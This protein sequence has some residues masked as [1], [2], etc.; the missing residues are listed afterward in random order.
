MKPKKAQ[1]DNLLNLKHKVENHPQSSL[2]KS[3]KVR[4]SL[5]KSPKIDLKSEYIDTTTVVTHCQ[6]IHFQPRQRHLC[7]NHEMG[8][9]R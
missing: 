5:K 1:V 6:G 9:C 8:A 3:L 7:A 2:E 4:S